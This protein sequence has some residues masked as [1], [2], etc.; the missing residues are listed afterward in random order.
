MK[1]TDQNSL[2]VPN[3]IPAPAQSSGVDGKTLSIGV[4]SITACVMFVGLLLLPVNERPVYAESQSVRGGDY[5]MTTFRV[6]S[7]REGIAVTDAAARMVVVY[8]WDATTRDMVLQ[9][10]YDLSRFDLSDRDRRR[11][12]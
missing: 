6:A 9:A 11:K 7:S 12:R 2:N 1:T 5:H 10:R 3:T 4:L 8:T